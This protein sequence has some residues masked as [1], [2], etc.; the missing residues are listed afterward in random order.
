[1]ILFMKE[2]GSSKTTVTT[3]QATQYHESEH[4]NLI[5]ST[6]NSSSFIKKR[7]NI[8]KTGMYWY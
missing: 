6:M 1:M 7:C 4:H 3:Y 5:Y 8:T 2:V